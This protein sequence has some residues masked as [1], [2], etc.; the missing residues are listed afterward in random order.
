VQPGALDGSGLRRVVTVLAVTVTTSY[1]VLYYGF[2]ALSSAITTATG[3]SIVAVTGA[4]SLSQLIAAGAGIWVGHHIDLVGPRRVM[5]ACSLL[6]VPAVVAIA[7]APDLAIF[8]AG[9]MLA[10]VAMSGLFYPPAF[11][12]LTHWGGE[13][14]VAALTTVTLV[15][16]FAST[17]FAPLASWSE[18]WWGWRGS[19]LLLLAVLVL[20]TVPLHWWGLNHPWPAGEHDGRYSATAVTN[21]TAPTRDTVSVAHSRA[22]LLL[23]VA[24]TLAALAIYAGL[25]NQV[26]LFI[27]HGMS[28]HLAALALGLGGVGQ[29]LG[30]LGYSQFAAHTTAASRLVLVALAVSAATAAL[31][32]ADGSVPSLLAVAMLLGMARGV[33]TL[34]GATAI[35]DRW[36]PAGYGTLN[37]ILTA[38]PLVAGA[39]AP[40]AGAA[41]ARLLGGYSDAFLVLAGVAALAALLA[42]ATSPDR[43]P[44]EPSRHRKEH[45]M[46]DRPSVLFVCVKNGGKSQMAA[47]LMRQVAG[48]AIAVDS[49]GTQPGP[50][51]NALSAASLAEVG[52]DISDQTPKPVT[53]DLVRAADV[54]VTLGRDAKVDPVAGTR[55]ENW[56]TDEPSARGIEGMERMR[57]VRDDIATRVRDLAA[58]LGVTPPV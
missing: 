48:D 53:G 52:I 39:S 17:V 37:G 56:D 42:L 4:F 15:A 57:L 9:W 12:A 2:A 1:G 19:Y 41:L 11:A 38:P 26:P 28:G 31:A 21:A 45:T 35:T 55:V 10:G 50:T 8:F 18:S 20:V 32:L 16:G 6:S 27:E 34:V 36:G 3:W 51:I 5:T 58:R 23:T 25:I 7:A 22:F 40:F 46:V 24:L 33:E 30:R 29:A 54:V 44:S 14:R 43:Q 49:A 47:G 13:R